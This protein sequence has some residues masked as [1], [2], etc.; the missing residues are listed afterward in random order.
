[1]LSNS[2]LTSTEFLGAFF[3]EYSVAKLET[4]EIKYIFL[5]YCLKI[6]IIIT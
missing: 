2:I 6:K 4:M 3:V 5:K 1:M